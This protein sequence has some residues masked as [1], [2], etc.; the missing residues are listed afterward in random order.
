MQGQKTGQTNRWRIAQWFERRWWK[1]Y[2]GDKTPEAYLAWKRTY[3]Q[4]FLEK[5]Q[6]HVPLPRDA[7]IPDAGCGPAGIF[8]LFPAHAVTAV[9]PLLEAYEQDLPHFQKAWY[10]NVR[11]ITSPLEDFAPQESF[12][13]IFCTNA[14]NH[15]R[16]IH[17]ALARLAAAAKP[18][19]T[20]IISIDAHK[21][22]WLVPLFE[23]IPGDILH[24]H[25]YSLKEYLALFERHGLKPVHSVLLKPEMIFDYYV[26]VCRKG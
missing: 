12:D 14:I 7:K 19:A 10:P 15:V 26:V 20:V 18:G 6:E 8:M 16:D 4:G 25:Q 21:H 5:I 22:R 9:D 1:K 17:L 3:W 11:F 23:L 13:L 24:P 2:L